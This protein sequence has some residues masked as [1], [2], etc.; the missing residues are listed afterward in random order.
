MIEK[1]TSNDAE[2]LSS[3]HYKQELKRSLKLF[4][5]FAV[6]FSFISITTGIFTNYQFVIQTGGAAGIWSWAITVL[7]Q[8]LVAFVFAELSS[9]IPVSGYSY[10]WIK[11]L[12]TP[13]ISWLTGWISFCFLI[14]VIPAVDWG[15][16]PILADLLSIPNTPHN[17]K[18]IVMAIIT[19]QVTLNIIGVKLASLIND[20]AVF[21]ETAGMIGLTIFLFVAAI[22][23][24]ADPAVLVH[25]GNAPGGT[26]Y[27]GPF[28]MTML[29]G[30][31]T[32]VGFEASA[33]LS[34]ETHHAHK[35]VPKAIISSVAISGLFGMLFLI[36]ATFAIQDMPGVLNSD[37]PL[38]FIIESSLGAVFGKLFLVLVCVS[39]FA[40]GLV[41]TTS[42]GRL[43]YAMSRD[44]AFFFSS[45]FKKISSKTN[46]P[47]QATLLILILCLISTYFAE[48]LTQLVGA[49]AVLP[50][51]IY[52]I[53][54]ISYALARKNVVFRKDCFA[55][56]K[57]ATP[58]FVAA[59]L[60]LVIEI[61]ILTIPQQFH[62]VTLMSGFMIAAGIVLYFLFFH[63]KNR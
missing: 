46:S 58:I 62:N 6:A 54:I 27:I 29:M 30:S 57:Y 41:I 26:S 45:T 53:T 44:D 39:I 56:G 43:I 4:S 52:L 13:F 10:Q 59:I 14:L 33:N 22:K 15:L 42:A 60:W 7:G 40:C 17:I 12:S 8:M 34:E 11:Q 37:N 3:F 23:N 47:I 35:T 1:Q 61:A 16:A 50:A 21:T 36:A 49:T 19:I 18:L 38:P 20:G 63:K 48:S 5:S 31:F 2:I 25:I 9:V 55:L 28:I 24:N 51:I 32:L